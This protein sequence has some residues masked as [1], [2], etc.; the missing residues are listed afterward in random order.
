MCL[1]CDLKYKLCLW[2]GIV[3]QCRCCLE[4]ESKFGDKEK[5]ID[6]HFTGIF[7][8]LKFIFL[9]QMRQKI[10]IGTLL[11]SKDHW[12]YQLNIFFRVF[13]FLKKTLDLVKSFTFLRFIYLYLSHILYWILDFLLKGE[14]ILKLKP[15][16][17]CL[18]KDCFDYFQC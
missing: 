8:D 15:E 17:F 14:M 12:L 3:L 6:N 11:Y 2:F 10:K 1:V 5:T 13:F 4:K 7:E 16:C 9:P 18:S